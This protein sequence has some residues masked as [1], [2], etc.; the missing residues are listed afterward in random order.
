[1]RPIL[2]FLLSLC[3]LPCVF[4]GT[5]TADDIASS[6]NTITEADIAWNKLN[7]NYQ[8]DTAS[9][10]SEF[11]KLHRYN[12]VDKSDKAGTSTSQKTPIINWNGIVLQARNFQEKYP[13]DPRIKEAKTIEVFALIRQVVSVHDP[14]NIDALKL[15]FADS[16]LSN[17][18]RYDIL[19]TLK[20]VELRLGRIKTR[21][22]L[23]ETRLAHARELINEFPENPKGYGYMLSVA[24]SIP[25]EKAASIARDISVMPSAPPEIRAGARRLASQREMEGKPFNLTAVDTQKYM[26]KPL[27]VYSW[28]TQ[29]QDV[30]RQVAR[31]ARNLDVQF[32]GV[33][34][35]EDKEFAR[36]V[37]AR[38]PL[39]HDQIYDGGGMDGPLAA[40]L[41]LTMVGSLYIVAKNGV[42]MD[43]SGHDNAYQKISRFSL[44]EN[45]GA[46]DTKAGG[47]Q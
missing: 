42:L 1:M 43:T 26:G 18:T 35:D 37:A 28:T 15:Y 25:G 21:N 16:S 11:N 4:A 20:G 5:V 29:R 30:L 40:E 41:Y 32:L 31:W 10:A 8:E 39:F 13:A 45:N 22:D 14:E 24:K 46:G 33:N 34:L 27:V 12:A 17:E 38:F 47:G 2:V 36:D 44:E 19:S 7:A 6:D 3:A 23:R 9:E